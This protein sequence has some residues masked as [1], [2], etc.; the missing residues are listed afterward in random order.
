MVVVVMAMLS[1]P[2]SWR[3]NR[4]WWPTMWV[5]LGKRGEMLFRGS[6][7]KQQKVER[8]CSRMAGCTNAMWAGQPLAALSDAWATLL[9]L[10]APTPVRL[11]TP[12]GTR[13]VPSARAPDSA[14]PLGRKHQAVKVIHPN[15]LCLD[16][17]LLRRYV[18]Y[19]ALYSV[20]HLPHTLF[21]FITSY[22]VVPR[23]S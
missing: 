6:G 23:Y 12:L 19:L 20:H 4:R 11:G 17:C 16:S 5:G 7:A 18:W 8:G 9:P 2:L 15:I 14:A 1:P 21:W 13:L 22:V 3:W 10:G